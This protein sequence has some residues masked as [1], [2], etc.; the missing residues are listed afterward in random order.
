[1]YG[2]PSSGGILLQPLPSGVLSAVMSPTRETVKPF[3]QTLRARI[4]RWT[5]R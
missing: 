3:M 1:V 2:D 4:G 5:A